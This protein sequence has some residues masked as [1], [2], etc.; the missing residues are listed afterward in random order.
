MNHDA[1]HILL[2]DDDDDDRLFFK[3]AI[4]EAKVKTVVTMV[5]DGVELMDYLCNPEMHLP[6]LLFLD[7]N[8]PCKS[9]MECLKEIRSNNK[10]K[11]LSIA[12]YSTSALEKDIEETFIKGAN[13]Y[14]KKPNDFEVLKDIL[15]KVITINWQYHTSGLNKENFL[16][17]IQ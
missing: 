6:N 7:L 11:D 15:A 13:I 12:I 8:M 17:H 10:L 3:D 1:L 16:L 5:N 9:G 2:A 14:I 4:Q